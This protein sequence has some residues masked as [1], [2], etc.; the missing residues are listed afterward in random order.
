MLLNSLHVSEI[1]FNYQPNKVNHE[2]EL[3]TLKEKI[4]D[5]ELALDIKTGT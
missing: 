4:R 1:S 5:L 3:N 2:E